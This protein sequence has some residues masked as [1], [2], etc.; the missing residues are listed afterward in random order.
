MIA[1]LSARWEISSNSCSQTVTILRDSGTADAIFG[2]IHTKFV[3]SFKLSRKCVIY[4][5]HKRTPVKERSYLPVF[6]SKVIQLRHSVDLRLTHLVQ[7][8]IVRCPHSP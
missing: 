8:S 1:G 5:A 7:T 6:F 3:G 4:L 2:L